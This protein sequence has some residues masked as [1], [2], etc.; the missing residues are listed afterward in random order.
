MPGVQAVF[1]LVM[2][3]IMFI[4]KA[5]IDSIVSFIDT[6]CSIYNII[7]PVLDLLVNQWTNTWT[8]MRDVVYGAGDFI[9]GIIS[10][11]KSGFKGMVNGVIGGLNTMI[12]GLNK[13]SFTVPDW[14]PGFGGDSFGFNLGEIPSY[15]VGT[16][17]L[18]SDMLIQAHE[19]EMIVPKSENPYANSTPGDTLPQ[20]TTTINFNGNYGF[21]D[22]AD[23]DYFMNQA[24]LK[25][26]G[27][28]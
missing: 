6:A 20:K 2:P 24:A 13:L 19:G 21:M 27:V 26:K 5:V 3:I 7:S 8:T 9:G 12:R 22:K 10:G 1:Q 25:L 23:I 28:R 15:A 4:I 16:R 18:P 11:I 14:V 17:Y